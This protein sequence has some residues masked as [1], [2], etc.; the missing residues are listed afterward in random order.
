MSAKE[1]FIIETPEKVYEA[2]KCAATEKAVRCLMVS[3]KPSTGSTEATL[4]G[5]CWIPNSAL[6]L[7]TKDLCNTYTLE[8]WF[9]PIFTDMENALDAY[10]SILKEEYFL[11]YGNKGKGKSKPHRKATA[12]EN[13]DN[14]PF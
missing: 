12:S 14:N 3:Y 7:L 8:K 13:T 1:F 4:E 5:F 11:I 6:S 2:Y 9:T 10:T